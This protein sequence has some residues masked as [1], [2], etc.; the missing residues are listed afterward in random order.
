MTV[1]VLYFRSVVG[2]VLVD[3]ETNRSPTPQFYCQRLLCYV[4]DAEVSNHYCVLRSQAVYDH[5]CY[6]IVRFFAQIQS[7]Y[8][9]VYDCT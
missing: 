9:V 8:S 7:T 1:T 2:S 4:Q 5:A 3:Q 6:G